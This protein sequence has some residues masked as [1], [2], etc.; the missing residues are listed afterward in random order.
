MRAKATKAFTLSLI[1]GS[2]HY[3]TLGC[4]LFPAPFGPGS[5][6]EETFRFIPEEFVCQRFGF[7][8]NGTA[9]GG[10]VELEDYYDDNL[11]EREK[12]LF[13][14]GSEEDP[15]SD[16]L[17]KGHAFLWNMNNTIEAKCNAADAFPG[18]YDYCMQNERGW[19]PPDVEVVTEHDT[20]TYLGLDIPRVRRMEITIG[21]IEAWGIF[22]AKIIS[23]AVG[24][25]QFINHENV[26]RA[27]TEEG[28]PGATHDFENMLRCFQQAIGGERDDDYDGLG[29]QGEGDYIN[30]HDGEV[31]SK[32]ARF[33]PDP[34]AKTIV[35]ERT[36]NPRALEFQENPDLFFDKG[37]RKYFDAEFGEWVDDPA[38]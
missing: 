9:F 27:Y 15:E 24:G 7:D 29:I 6:I 30:D 26:V 28:Y 32:Y 19:G 8:E 22:S 3:F 5:L 36:W 4:P 17:G 31:N 33:L 23:D 1:L 12:F 37:P 34:N 25:V 14:F 38:E 13:I 21:P 11:E 35:P 18:V 2:L 10:M 16:A 20:F